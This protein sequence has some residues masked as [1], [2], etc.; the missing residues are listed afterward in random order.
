MLMPSITY[1]A[2]P[3][4]QAHLSL[5]THGGGSTETQ[6]R[7]SSAWGQPGKTSLPVGVM[8]SAAQLSVLPENS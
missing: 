4:P 2:P 3:L 5:P 1:S 6:W 8:P 7:Q